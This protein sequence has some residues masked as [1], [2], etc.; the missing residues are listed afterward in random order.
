MLPPLIMRHE[1]SQLLQ[2]VEAK[3]R[4]L[5]EQDLLEDVPPVGSK[6]AS[7]IVVLRKSDR[8]VRVCGNYKISVITKFSRIHILYQMLKFQFM[9]SQVFKKNLKMT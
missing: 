8:D 5:I 6:W 4:K 7:A 9:H 2:L 3:L 1:N